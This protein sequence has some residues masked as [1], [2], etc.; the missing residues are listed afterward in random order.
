M[1]GGWF[2]VNGAKY[3][4]MLSADERREYKAAKQA[5][6]RKRRKVVKR[7]G[8]EAGATQAIAEGLAESNEEARKYHE[9]LAAE[10]AVGEERA[11]GD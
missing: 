4:A 2:V 3:R 9:A 11:P 1:D 7:D 10:R 6:Y 8:A 5:E